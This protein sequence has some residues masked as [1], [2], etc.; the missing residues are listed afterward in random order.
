[1]LSMD[2]IIELC[3]EVGNDLGKGYSEHVYQEGI[4]VL[5]RQ[6]KINYSKEVTLSIFFKG[7]VIGTVRADIVIPDEQIIIECKAI[8]NELRVNCLPQL[9]NYLK[10]TNY[11]QGIFVNF[12]QNPSK[13]MVD[14]IKMCRCTFDKTLYEVFMNDKDPIYI[15]NTGMLVTNDS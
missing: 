14:I 5:L 13:K 10:L 1:M 3:K 7:L 15:D 4:A 11:D 9:V 2:K 6:N 12:N 8:D